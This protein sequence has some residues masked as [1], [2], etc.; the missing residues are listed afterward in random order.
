MK[1]KSVD[2]VN[3]LKDKNEKEWDHTKNLYWLNLHYSDNTEENELFSEHEVREMQEFAKMNGYEGHIPLHN[4]IKEKR[5]HFFSS[6]VTDGD[7]HRIV[8]QIL[9]KLKEHFQIK[10]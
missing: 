6:A 10:D 4:W 3:F 9:Q 5:P 2:E 8:I 7:P 1:N